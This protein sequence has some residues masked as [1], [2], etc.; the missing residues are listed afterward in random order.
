MKQA[1]LVLAR[2][3]HLWWREFFVLTFFNLAWLALQIP[4]ITGP[5][6]TAAMYLIA[7]R[8]A[9]D[10]LIELRHG[11]EALRQMFLPAWKWGAVNLLM[12]I[13][14]GTNFVGYRMQTGLGWTMLRVVW[15]TIALAWFAMNLFYWPFWLAQSDR[16]LLTTYRNSA[17]MLMKKP[18]LGMTLMLV[19]ALVIL[20]SVAV[21]LPFAAALMTWLALL[22]VLAVDEALRP[23]AAP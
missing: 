17:L 8:V 1:G 23:D 9:D 16:R 3:I 2:T 13:V 14:L 18:A 20:I 15:G 21:T 10:E 11:W 5:P 19:S 4:I 7:R 6:A 12:L 22:G